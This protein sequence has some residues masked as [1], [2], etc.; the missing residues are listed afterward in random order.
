MSTHTI[1]THNKFRIG[2]AAAL[3]TVLSP[4]VAH[5]GASSGHSTPRLVGR[6]VL[7]VETYSDGPPSGAGLVP[8]GQ[9][10]TVINGVTFPTPSQ[11]VEGFSAILPGRSPGSFAEFD[12]GYGGRANSRIRLP[13]R[14]LRHHTRR[15][16]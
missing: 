1:S 12:N 11:P 16:R 4:L 5:A 14:R 6:A 2:C 13:P 3:V 7:P 15:I 8:A 10:T 9:T